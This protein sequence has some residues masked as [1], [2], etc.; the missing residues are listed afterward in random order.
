M[1]GEATE[2][3]QVEEKQDLIYSGIRSLEQ[4]CEEWLVGGQERPVSSCRNGPGSTQ[5]WGR[6]QRGLRRVACAE[7]KFP[8][9]QSTDV[10][11]PGGQVAVGLPREVSPECSLGCRQNAGVWSTYMQ[12][13]AA[14]ECQ[15]R[16]QPAATALGIFPPK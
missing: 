12:A 16:G 2:S 3:F 14:G 6:Q 15:G 9:L 11:W 8:R 5:G 13:L 4:L 10:Y 1:R 7:A